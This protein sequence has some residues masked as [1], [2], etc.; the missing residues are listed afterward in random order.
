M[1]KSKFFI[2]S[3]L[4]AASLFSSC[5]KTLNED[6]QSIIAP[7]AFFKTADQCRQATNGV[8]SHLPGI[9]NQTGFWS[10]TLAGTDLFMNQGGNATIEAIQDYNFS[11]ATETNSHAVWQVCYAGIKDANF[12]INRISLSEIDEETK[13]QL[14]GENKFL[15]AMYYHLLTN[16]F[17]DV[18]LWIDELKI[19]EVSQLPRSPL[20][21]VRAQMILDLED[22]IASLPANYDSSNMGRVTK[23]AALT[24][25]A[26]IYLYAQDWE[27]AYQMASQVQDGEYI[28]LPNYADLFDPYNKSKNNKESIFEIQYKRNAETNQNFVT[29]SFYTY[30]FPTGDAA[31]GTYAGVDFGT[32]IL[33]SYPQFYPTHYLIDLYDLDDDRRHVSLSWGF[34]GELFNR[35]SIED[36][37]WFGPKFWDLTANR[38]ASEKNLY[39]L[40]YAEVIMILAEAANE[41]GNTADALTYVNMIRD[42]AKAE[43]LGAG[44]NLNQ[45]QMREVIMEERAREFVGEFHRKWDL[46]RWN[47]LGEAMESIAEENADGARNVQAHHGLFPIP[48]DE[49][50]KNRNL[51][52]NPGYN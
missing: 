10:V 22:A 11:S 17:G 24:L 12:V 21:E 39:F 6:P 7:D 44:D 46:S 26:R 23:G 35:G 51:E 16:V 43:L 47:K 45:A 3:V 49:I 32:V 48:Y 5:E 8:Y 37:P 33:Q 15:R 18:P 52:Q 36:R 19:D 41:M 14:L 2:I 27:N 4:S 38:T 31:G 34:N 1:L 29:N 40:R 25:L 28:L 20:A 42:R 13:H 9:F 50:V 30:F